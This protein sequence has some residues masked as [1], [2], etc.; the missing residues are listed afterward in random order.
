MT[1][2]TVSRSAYGSCRDCAQAGRAAWRW[3]PERVRSAWPTNRF[4][5]NTAAPAAV[6]SVAPPVRR[7]HR[8]PAEV[9]VVATRPARCKRSR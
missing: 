2:M 8:L 3:G 5:V 4:A 1:T 7:E 6:G 9:G